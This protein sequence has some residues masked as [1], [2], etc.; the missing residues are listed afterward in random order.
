MAGASRFIFTAL[1]LFTPGP[2]E[3]GPVSA[4]A[5]PRVDGQAHSEAEEIEG[6]PQAGGA[7]ASRR[8]V[9]AARAAA[10][11]RAQSGV[12][13]VDP[14]VLTALFRVGEDLVRFADLAELPCR[15]RVLREVG[16]IPQRETAECG[17]DR[18]IVGRRVDVE[19]AVVIDTAVKA[20]GAPSIAKSEPATAYAATTARSDRIEP[21]HEEAAVDRAREEHAAVHLEAAH[22]VR[23][24]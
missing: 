3:E 8:S 15:T 5:R 18:G 1:T 7:G 17:P 12:G 14:I 11:E 13:P 19:G 21:E 2:T 4:A 22:A 9:L 23:S 6:D 16:V 10:D 20:N 24:V